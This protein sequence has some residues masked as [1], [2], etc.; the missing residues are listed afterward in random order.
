MCHVMFLKTN[1]MP[2]YI[3]LSKI[4]CILLESMTQALLQKPLCCSF[5]SC[6]YLPIVTLCRQKGQ[7]LGNVHDHNHRG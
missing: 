6:T 4:L 1:R 3:K 5:M 7:K 2:Q